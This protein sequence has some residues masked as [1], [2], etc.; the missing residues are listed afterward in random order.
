M[1]KFFGPTVP[2]L[3]IRTW[4]SNP[5]IAFFFGPATPFFYSSKDVGPSN[6]FSFGP[7]VPLYLQTLFQARSAL[8]LSEYEFLRFCQIHF[9]THSAHQ[10]CS[11]YGCLP[12]EFLSHNLQCFS[13][14]RVVGY[15]PLNY[16]PQARRASKLLE[17]GLF[18]PRIISTWP[19]A[20]LGHSS[21]IF[22]FA[23]QFFWLAV[24]LC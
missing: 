19:S 11:G 13:D 8:A 2:L 3:Y 16:S 22:E 17:C 6:H 7:L 12:L 23:S 10:R 1:L 15:G 20:P 4:V 9:G 18:V 5:Q 14:I 21:M 24:P